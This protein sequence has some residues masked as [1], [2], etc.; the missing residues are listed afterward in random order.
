MR[1]AILFMGIVFICTLL[2]SIWIAPLYENGKEKSILFPYLATAFSQCVEQKTESLA[3]NLAKHGGFTFWQAGIA[4]E[5]TIEHE[6]ETGMSNVLAGCEE[7]LHQEEQ[8]TRE[9]KG[10]R[11][12]V[13]PTDIRVLLDGRWTSRSGKSIPGFVIRIKLPLGQYA[14]RAKYLVK[15]WE[16][17]G[18]L[19][20]LILSTLSKRDVRQAISKKLQSQHLEREGD[21]ISLS[22]SP[23][24]IKADSIKREISIPLTVTMKNETM[25]NDAEF[26]FY[27]PFT[28][29]AKDILSGCEIM[30]EPVNLPQAKEILFDCGWYSC[31]I[32]WRE[33]IRLPILCAKPVIY[34]DGKEYER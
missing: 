16:E 8:F 14:Q 27:Y 19:R 17:T 20:N 31:A 11:A 7:L 5:L 32:P 25:K 33:S 29:T 4:N 1:T 26:Q 34:L 12:I 21:T 2:L 6:L 15:T 10:I 22:V 28:L 3:K 18:F 30:A 23:E 13:E 24:Q 9:I